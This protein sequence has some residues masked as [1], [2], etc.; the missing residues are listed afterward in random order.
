MKYHCKTQQTCSSCNSLIC[1][2]AYSEEG[3][4]KEELEQRVLRGLIKKRKLHLQSPLCLRTIK[5]TAAG[6]TCN[7]CG[8]VFHKE[9]RFNEE[10]YNGE[11]DEKKLRFL[12]EIVLEE[13]KTEVLKHKESCFFAHIQTRTVI[14][15]KVL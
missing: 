2:E 9:K 4:T 5:V 13:F 7:R 1:F 10:N 11:L 6:Y 15:E 3:E 12:E 8:E 14:I